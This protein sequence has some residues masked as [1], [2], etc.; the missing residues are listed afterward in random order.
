MKSFGYATKTSAQVYTPEA[1]FKHSPKVSLLESNSSSRDGEIVR[2]S[3][4]A[5]AR[6]C[7]L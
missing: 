1:S 3:Q 4:P 2:R 6:I 5:K 7:P